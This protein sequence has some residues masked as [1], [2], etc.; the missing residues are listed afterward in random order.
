MQAAA[1]IA[2]S[3]RRHARPLGVRTFGPSRPCGPGSTRQPPAARTD[4]V[5]ELTYGG[6]RARFGEIERRLRGRSAARCLPAGGGVGK[7]KIA[8]PGRDREFEP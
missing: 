7:Q 4:T 5:Q 8:C 1:G 2:G 3:S 6:E